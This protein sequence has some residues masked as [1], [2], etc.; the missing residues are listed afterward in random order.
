M[1]STCC[2]FQLSRGAARAGFCPSFLPFSETHQAGSGPG[3]CRFSG[4]E[5]GARGGLAASTRPPQRP[6]PPGTLDGA[7]GAFWTITR[8]SPKPPELL[9]SLQ[10]CQV[11]P[12]QRSLGQV[13]SSR[14]EEGAGPSCVVHTAVLCDPADVLCK[15]LGELQLENIVLAGPLG[16]GEVSVGGGPPEST[17]PGSSLPWLSLSLS[18]SLQR[19]PAR[20]PGALRLGRGLSFRPLRLSCG[21]TSSSPSQVL[22]VLYSVGCTT[23]SQPP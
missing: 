15:H 9:C 23:G 6:A 12:K 7:H 11:R 10:W 4:K 17:V 18:C 22:G 13:P 1:H 14:S 19:D 8:L 2:C 16:L 20:S 3:A 21:G 5:V